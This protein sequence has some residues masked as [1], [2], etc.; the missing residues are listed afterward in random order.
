MRV[1]YYLGMEPHKTN[2]AFNVW[3]TMGSNMD[4]SV[5]RSS[6]TPELII[7]ALTMHEND[8]NEVLIVDRIVKSTG[9]QVSM[10]KHK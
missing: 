9:C 5:F 10:K 8:Y 6:K 1:T 4:Y 2:V 3:Y 7:I